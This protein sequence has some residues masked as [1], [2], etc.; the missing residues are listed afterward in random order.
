MRLETRELLKSLVHALLDVESA[1]PRTVKDM[2]LRPGPA[3]RD[4]VAGMRRR[5]VGPAQYF[6]TAL[7]VLFLVFVC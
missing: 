7:A 5:Y 2:T 6:V 1:L 3:V 4:Y